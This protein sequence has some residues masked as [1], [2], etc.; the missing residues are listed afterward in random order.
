MRLS[1]SSMDGSGCETVTG[2]LVKAKVRH[3]N[4]GYYCC[5]PQCSNRSSDKTLHF[6]RFPADRNNRKRW[7]VA[8]RRDVGANFVITSHTRVCSAFGLY[9]ELGGASFGPRSHTLRFQM[10]EA[11][12]SADDS[13]PSSD[14]AQAKGKQHQWNFNGDRCDRRLHNGA[15]FVSG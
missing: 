11:A 5:V 14:G 4:A 6:H 2:A 10:V 7:C 12:R 1:R 9:S 15:G 13:L 3:S 8:I